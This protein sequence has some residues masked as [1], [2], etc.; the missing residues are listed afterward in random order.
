M[1]QIFTLILAV[2]TL[3]TFGQSSSWDEWEKESETNKRLLPK[4]GNQVKSEE[5]KKS[6]QKF[7][8]EIMTQEQFKGDKRA[9]SNHMIQLGFNY[10]YRRDLKTAMYRFNQAFLLDSTNTDIYWG[11][12]AIYM[13]LGNFELGKQ[14]YIEGLSIDSTNAHLLT[15]LSTYYMEQYFA[16]I[17]MPENEYVKNPKEQARE[18]LDSAINYLKKSYQIDPKDENTLF[19][20]STVYYYADDCE[21]AWK[22]YDECKKLG[23]RPITESYTKDLKK[24]CKRKK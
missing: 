1:K 15:D 20:L 3:T 9:A 18:N 22:Y 7:V 10:M 23:G 17:M 19:K 16:M 5:E 13:T 4:Y 2:I 11:Y 24:K 21:N 14:Q 6:D 12:G 8:E